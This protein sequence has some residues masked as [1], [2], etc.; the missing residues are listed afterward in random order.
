[1]AAALPAETRSLRGFELDLLPDERFP[2]FYIFLAAW[3]GPPNGS[4][5]IG[6]YAVDKSTGDVWNATSECEELS[7]PAL[8]SLQRKIRRRIGVSNSEYRQIKRKGPLCP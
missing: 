4:L 7:T 6:H 3:A 8:Q 2:N 1:V 5:V